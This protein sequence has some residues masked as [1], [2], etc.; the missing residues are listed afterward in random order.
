[1]ARAGMTQRE[2][3]ERQAGRRSLSSFP[4][5]SCRYNSYSRS[6]LAAPISRPK[7]WALRCDVAAAGIGFAQGDRDHG[8][9]EVFA[10]TGDMRRIAVRTAGRRPRRVAGLDQVEVT[11]GVQPVSQALGHRR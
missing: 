5:A 4:P 7:L 6:N 8:R 11:K 9:L 10:D 1:M 2:R 3:G